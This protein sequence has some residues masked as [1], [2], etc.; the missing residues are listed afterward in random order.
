MPTLQMPQVREKNPPPVGCLTLGIQI[1]KTSLAAMCEKFNSDYLPIH[2][3]EV[4]YS[5]EPKCKGCLE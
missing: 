2:D 5:E 1:E 4:C 3:L